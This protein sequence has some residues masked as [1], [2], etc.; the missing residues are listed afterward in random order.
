METG[1]SSSLAILRPRTTATKTPE[2]HRRRPRDLSHARPR[3]LG[4]ETIDFGR[5]AGTTCRAVEVREAQDTTPDCRLLQLVERFAPEPL[6]VV[7]LSRPELT[8]RYVLYFDF[9]GQDPASWNREFEGPVR[10][11]IAR[12]YVGFA[13]SFVHPFINELPGPGFD[14]PRYELVLQYW[15]FYPYNDAGNIHEGDWEHINVVVSPRTQGKDMLT[16][17]TMRQLLEHPVAHDELV[18]NRVEYYFHYWVFIADYLTPNL[19]APRVDWRS[20]LTGSGC[21]RSCGPIP[22]CAAGGPGSCCRSA[23]DIPR[24]DHR[25]PASSA[26]R[27]PGIPRSWPHRT[28]VGGTASGMPR[29]RTRHVHHQRVDSRRGALGGPILWNQSLPRPPVRE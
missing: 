15:F 29:A 20:S 23:L 17:A 1:I 26:T 28:M 6:P 13:K 4:T 25:S 19:Y 18:I 27:K 9:P 11:T 22:P 7:T 10:G 5:L 24:P 3:L 14:Q 21:S 8:L 2:R 16:E 12:K